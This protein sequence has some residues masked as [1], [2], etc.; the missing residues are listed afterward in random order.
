MVKM[1]L[2]T[3]KNGLFKLIEKYGLDPSNFIWDSMSTSRATTTYGYDE[4]MPVLIY[5]ETDFYFSI[6]YKRNKYFAVFSPGKKTLDETKYELTWDVLLSHFTEWLRNLKREIEQPALWK[7]LLKYSPPSD[8]LIFDESNEQFT[9]KELIK[10]SKGI[11]NIRSYLETEFNLHAEQR[12]KVNE[13]LEYLTS[14]ASRL[15]KKDWYNILF[16]VGFQICIYLSPSP[17]KANAFWKFINSTFIRIV[18]LLPHAP[19]GI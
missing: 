9:E 3:Q 15:T 2:T 7:E 8:K 16:T 6:D 19:S 1:L 13:Q 18:Q 17:E 14:A 12:G 10:I 4:K 5:K 11:D